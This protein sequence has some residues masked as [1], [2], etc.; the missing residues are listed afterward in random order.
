[1]EKFDL[2]VIGAGPAGY[3]GAMRALDF[4]KSVILIEKDKVGGAGIYNGALS[5]KATWELAKKI[6]NVTKEIKHLSDKAYDIKYSEVKEVV[7]SAIN[8][9]KNQ[10]EGHIKLLQ[11]IYNE[12]QF[13]FVKGSAYLKTKNIVSIQTDNGEQIIEAKYILVTTGSKPRKLPHIP[14][15]EKHIMTSDGLMNLNEFP[16]SLVILGAGVIGCE[17]ATMF[18]NFGKTKVHIIDKVD[19]I[20]PFEDEDVVEI[21]A[22]NF[23]KNGVFI[24]KSS[25]LN[26]MEVIDGEVEYEVLHDDGS[27]KVFRVEKALVSI[28]RIPNSTGLGLEEV[29]VRMNKEG[30]LLD[31]DTQTTV[32]NIFVAGDL[33][34]RVCLVNVGEL[35][36]REAVKRMFGKSVPMQ[37]DIISNIMFL[38]P[39]VAGV[40]K[41]EKQL[42]EK[43]I[44]YKMVKIDF[45]CIVRAI[46]MRKTQGF[47]KIMVTDDDEMRILGMRALGVHASTA[48]LAVAMVISN[49][50][51]IRTL[52]ELTYPHPSIIE[53]IQEC[54]RMILNKSIFKPD[55]FKDKLV[56][57]RC[58]NGICTPIEGLVEIPT[59]HNH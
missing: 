31:F 5:S 47:F 13:K 18:S 30:Y 11:G 7:N 29:G 4:G 58:S 52:A 12:Q 21:I 50:Q 38:N 1:M 17:Y 37:Y 48:I 22:S 53:G 15:D 27:T 39:E 28:G 42:Q 54:V 14:I 8:E 44:P 36:A 34:G 46:A 57:Y 10:L 41:N 19:R 3:A 43:G 49:K 16:K 2:C 9:R 51:S 20:L 25:S 26:R 40:G 59:H 6:H 35:E 32:P 33:C 24:H 55:L 45:S 56:I 23:E